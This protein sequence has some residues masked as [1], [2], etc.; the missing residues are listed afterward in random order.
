MGTK[1]MHQVKDLVIDVKHDLVSNDSAKLGLT[2]TGIPD[3]LIKCEVSKAK[4]EE[5]TA[6][7]LYGFGPSVL[8]TKISG[9]KKKPEF[10]INFASGPFFGALSSKDQLKDV[11]GHGYYKLSDKATISGTFETSKMAAIGKWS[12]GGVFL[13]GYGVAAKAKL[14]SG[15]NVTVGLKKA[16]AKGFTVTAGGS[17]SGK[18]PMKYGMK[19]VVE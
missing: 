11:I 9:M 15:M 3:A 19:V 4:P 12:V 8:G 7:V 14:E 18:G 5:F 6:D 13:P 16:L 17:Y 2:Y 10:A 1:D